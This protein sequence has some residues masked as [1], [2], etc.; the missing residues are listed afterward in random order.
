[1]S[2]NWGVILLSKGALVLTQGTVTG[3]CIMSPIIVN[4]ESFKQIEKSTLSMIT[5][6]GACSSIGGVV[7]GE[8]EHL[9]HNAF[10]YF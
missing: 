8:V 4:E 7:A 5:I 9:I 2:N 6:L 3:I 1:M 10:D